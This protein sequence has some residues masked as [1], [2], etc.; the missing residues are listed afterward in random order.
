MT[1]SRSQSRNNYSCRKVRD[2]LPLHVGGD[3]D[4]KH[5][6]PVD[7]H[8][9]E[10]LACFREFRAYATLRGRL[11]VVGEAPLPAGALDGF[12]DEVMARIALDEPGP[13]AESPRASSVSFW[14]SGGARIRAAAAVL[15]VGLVGW[16]AWQAFDDAGE[17]A[18]H[19]TLA[20]DTGAAAA[21]LDVMTMAGGIPV[22]GALADVIG[23]NPGPTLR[24]QNTTSSLMGPSREMVPVDASGGH[25]V[26]TTPLEPMVLQ[27]YLPQPQAPKLRPVE[28]REL[29]VRPR[30]QEQ[31]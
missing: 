23:E 25:L 29:R 28:D 31:R 6:G 17:A 15:V 12:A 7:E 20:V 4:T 9:H 18:P 21:G 16:Q 3:L 27:V 2:L 26:P 22:G 5:V 30:W 10:C 14:R 1:T 24:P 8:L 13:A 11:G 19:A